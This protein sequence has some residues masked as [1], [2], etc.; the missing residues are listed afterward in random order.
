LSENFLEH[1]LITRTGDRERRSSALLCVLQFLI[2]ILRL[3]ISSPSNHSS[4]KSENRKLARVTLRSL[5]LI[6]VLMVVASAI[7]SDEA[8]A[9]AACSTDCYHMNVDWEG[10]SSPQGYPSVTTV[11]NMYPYCRGITAWYDAGYSTPRWCPACEPTATPAGGGGA[12]TSTAT[13]TPTNTPAGPTSTSTSTPTTTP[14]RTPTRTPTVTPTSAPGVPT[15]TPTNTPTVTPTSAPGMPTSTPTNTPTGGPTSNPTS[16]PTSSAPTSTPTVTPTTTSVS[17]IWKDSTDDLTIFRTNSFY[18]TN[19]YQ[20]FVD[21]CQTAANNAGIGSSIGKTW[22][23]IV[24]DQ[25]FNA[26]DL[27]S[28]T[29]LN[30]A[31]NIWNMNCQVVAS[32]WNDLWTTYPD[33]K[34]NYNE[35][36]NPANNSGIP[37][38]EGVWSATNTNG[39]AATGYTCNNWANPPSLT[40]QPWVGDPDAANSA[41]WINWKTLPSYSVGPPMDPGCTSSHPIYCVSNYVKSS[42]STPT[43]ANTPTNTATNTPGGPT[44]TPTNTPAA[45]TATPSNTPTVTPTPDVLCITGA[46]LNMPVNSCPGPGGFHAAGRW[47]P[48]IYWTGGSL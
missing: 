48:E 46:D 15:A 42:C 12:A 7:F 11:C 14:T 27:V 23:P 19:G 4:A 33:Y 29:N 25:N 44:N 34:L 8:K 16:T 30:T 5:P 26:I 32:S 6:A 41:N 38:Y 1:S 3:T 39:T 35:N 40:H 9:Q 47:Y 18:P 2:S 22:Y 28:A 24:S 17:S 21:A 20:S 36:S 10:N 37:G 45:P 43:P 13:N 31:R